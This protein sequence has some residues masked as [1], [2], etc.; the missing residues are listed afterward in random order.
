MTVLGYSL[1]EVAKILGGLS[2]LL[3]F[4]LYYRIMN[5]QSEQ[6]KI[7]QRQAE[8]MERQNTLM[9][10]S[11]KP[12]IRINTDKTE[13]VD[14]DII[15]YLTN[16]GNGMAKDLRVQCDTHAIGNEPSNFTLE[17]ST[18]LLRRS[19]TAV[20]PDH[21]QPPEP[22]DSILA[23]EEDRKFRTSI[24]IRI[25]ENEDS[26]SKALPLGVAINRLVEEGLEEAGLHF[27]LEYSD[28][29]GGK[30][31][32]QL[33][34]LGRHTDISKNITLE[35]IMQEGNQ[36]ATAGSLTVEAPPTKLEKLRSWIGI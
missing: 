2:P 27:F 34:N 25:S 18:N 4:Y 12:D 32:K 31:K 15:I 3:L 33:Y 6:T 22:D 13:V 9:E 11:F 17:S 5:I 14:N 7:Q 24:S 23:G 29:V 26:T 30:D 36:S 21:E 20:M 35:D 8:I 1:L 19:T 10:A 16:L 28:I